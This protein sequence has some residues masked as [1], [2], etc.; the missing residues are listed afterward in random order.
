[1]DSSEDQILASWEAN[2]PEWVRVVQERLIVSRTKVTDR[3]IVEAVGQGLGRWGLDLGCGEGWLCGALESQGWRM[4]GV[5]GSHEL[6]EA[7]RR[8]GCREAHHLRYRELGLLPG[9]RVYDLIVCNFS[10]L[11]E[12]STEEA[13]VG[14]RTILAPGGAIW[15]QTVHPLSLS[16]PYQSGW[17]LEDWRGF[18]KARFP[19]PS[20]W[21]FRTLSDWVALIAKTGLILRDLREPT[22]AGEPGPASLIVSLQSG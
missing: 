13:L 7:A 8:R 15:I 1:M 10:L 21:Y 11:G 2:A 4:V 12:A 3:A 19:S 6:V 22:V 17:Q 18:G 16:I 9:G 20:P 14:A 5:D